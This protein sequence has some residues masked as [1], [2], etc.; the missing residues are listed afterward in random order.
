MFRKLTA[1]PGAAAPSVAGMGNRTCAWPLHGAWGKD[2]FRCSIL[3]LMGTQRPSAGP[4]R[5]KTKL[6][7]RDGLRASQKYRRW[8]SSAGWNKMRWAPGQNNSADPSR[9]PIEI[10]VFVSWRLPK[11]VSFQFCRNQDEW[12]YRHPSINSCSAHHGCL[13]VFWKVLIEMKDKTG[14]AEEMPW[15]SRVKLPSYALNHRHRGRYADDKQ[16][17]AL[18]FKERDRAPRRSSKMA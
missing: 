16:G 17:Y 18:Y 10:P 14:A 8:L 1:A 4:A 3:E 13:V 7:S 6:L 2:D 9:T 5:D 12:A 11:P 15:A